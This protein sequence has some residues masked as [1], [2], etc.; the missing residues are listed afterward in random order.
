MSHQYGTISERRAGLA[1]SGLVV[2]AFLLRLPGLAGDAPWIDEAASIGLG[3]LPWGVVFG[4]MARIEASPP[5]YYAIAGLV[6]R[7]AGPAPEP[8][9]LLSAL[10][11][12][13]AVLPVFLFCRAAFGSRAAWVA[14]CLV[15]LHGSLIRHGQD[16]RTYALLFLLFC[17][18]LFAAQRLVG[19]ARDG[20]RGAG[21]VL[22]LGLLQ[23]AMLWLHHT[24]AIANLALN[25]FVLVALAAGGARVAAG[26]AR[27]AAADAIGLALGAA[28]ILWAL[29]HATDGAFVT[30]WI[31]PPG[32]MDTALI[33][34]RDVVA[35]FHSPL[36]ALTLTLTAAG[37]TLA[38]LARA[39]VGRAERLALVAMLAFAG[40]AFPLVSQHWPV[41]VDRTVLFLVAP[42]AAGAAAGLALLPRR[43]FLA[44]A[45]LLLALH[46]FG[47]LRFHLLPLTREDWNGVAA[48]LAER[49]APGDR[50][51]VTDSVFALVSL[52]AAAG[53]A[54][55]EALLVPA[56]SP[57]E[58][59]SA[60]LLAPEA[61]VA[62]QALCPLLR[63]AG[64]AWII[65]RS[66]PPRVA[67]DMTFTTW[68]AVR[69][70]LT[71]A[72]GERLEALALGGIAI[73]RW[74]PPTAC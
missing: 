12:A 32:L 41:L 47:A 45:A 40:L 43:A 70:A 37:L 52:R 66:V 6:G 9:R 16:G 21:A 23:G 10:A 39:P 59:R 49:M 5:G 22:A 60:E 2:F 20:R 61:M 35:P 42:V 26:L 27:L 13:L 58:R 7:V 55:L 8:L 18:A 57:L 15:A 24:A 14:A 53:G 11:A 56:A 1:L 30:R 34:A 44:A 64:A 72:G 38:V 46:G 51:V 28:P 33:Y 71:Q 69:S 19:A 3:S 36:S 74:R 54:P 31:A 65:T 48:L 73:E 17:C 29:G 67:E 50:I 4:D 25:L 62:A 63:G 68:P